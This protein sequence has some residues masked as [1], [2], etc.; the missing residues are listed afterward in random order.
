MNYYDISVPLSPNSPTFP[1]DPTISFS[2]HYQIDNGDVCNLTTYS[3]GS[4]SATHIDVPL[5]FLAD[6]KS[7][8]DMPI[9][10]F[11]G[12]ALVVDAT[13]CD[14]IAA[15]HVANLDIAPGMNILFKTDNKDAL[16]CSEFK[17]DFVHVGIEAAEILS[18]KKVN[19]VGVDYL[20]VEGFGSKDF[21]VHKTLLSNNIILLEGIRLTN[22]EPGEYTLSALPIYIPG[23]N[24]SP[25]RAILYI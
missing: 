6:G 9:E 8:S 22:I 23:A 1:G 3:F 18:L 7:V 11:I 25:V 24:G 4:H 2:P 5:H 10:R 21:K 19:M 14:I 20:S 15:E 12:P 17:K 13:G 16:L